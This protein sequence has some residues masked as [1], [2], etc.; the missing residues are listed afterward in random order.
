MPS[1]KCRQGHDIL[2]TSTSLPR[3]YKPQST[4]EPCGALCHG[5]TGRDDTD[6]ADVL[7]LLCVGGGR[8]LP[9]AKLYRC[10]LVSV[11]QVSPVRCD[12][13]RLQCSPCHIRGGRHLLELHLPWPAEGRQQLSCMTKLW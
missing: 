5:G 2:L 11:R 1:L 4:Q 8:V 3:C 10:Q 13:K 7:Q 12:Q 9:D 6:L